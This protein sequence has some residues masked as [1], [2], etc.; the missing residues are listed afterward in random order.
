MSDSHAD[1]TPMPQQD[2]PDTDV[3]ENPAR[4]RILTTDQAVA[5]DIVREAKEVLPDITIQTVLRDAIHAGLP[6]VRR[7]MKAICDAAKKTT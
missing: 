7:K 3:N 6:V 2:T 4:L 1:D 5:A